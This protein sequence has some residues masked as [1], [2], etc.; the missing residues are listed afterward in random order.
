MREHFTNIRT[1]IFANRD[2]T[3]IDILVH[4]ET[5]GDIT[6]TATSYDEMD[7]GRQLFNELI[8]GLHGP[9]KEFDEGA[10]S[11]KLKGQ[12]EQAISDIIHSTAY[13][14]FELE[15]KQKIGVITESEAAYKNELI[16]YIATLRNNVECNVDNVGIPQPPSKG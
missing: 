5:H 10:F 13:V 1:P 2:E 9:I 12:I 15:C 8:A 14:V 4:H 3:A 7:Y 6:F 16:N 11:A